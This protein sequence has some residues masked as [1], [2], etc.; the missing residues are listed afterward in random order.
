MLS[1]HSFKAVR[2]DLIPYLRVRS[3]WIFIDSNDSLQIHFF[4]TVSHVKNKLD[5]LW[6]YLEFPFWYF[7]CPFLLIFHCPPITPLFSLYLPLFQVFFSSFFSPS[8]IL[9]PQY[10]PPF[11]FQSI[12]LFLLWR[13]YYQCTASS[14]LRLKCFLKLEIGAVCSWRH[15]CR[16]KRACFT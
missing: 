10:L 4:S 13:Q 9:L 15:S 7:C 1:V 16:N 6:W 11:L 12:T 14:K 5:L 3:C 2:A 8:V